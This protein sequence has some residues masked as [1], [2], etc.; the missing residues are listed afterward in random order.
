QDPPGSVLYTCEAFILMGEIISAVDSTSLDEVIRK[1]V[2]E[3]LGMKD[4]CYKPPV[5][6]IDRIAPTEYCSI[7]DRV[8]R[9]EVHDENAWVM[10]GVSGNA[11]IFS[12]A[13]DMTRIGAAMLD[14]LEKGTF[15]HKATAELMCRNYTPGMGENRGLGWMI[16]TR[17]TS[18]GDLLSPR[19]FGHTGF[20]GTSLWID[21][22]RKLY[23]LLLTNRVHPTRENTK[24]FRTR[25]IFH[26]LAVLTYGDC[27][28]AK[29][30]NNG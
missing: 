13:P 1:R 18:S 19:S 8:V 2:W 28:N 29:Q 30:G 16:A 27:N 17:G 5:S 21:P 25:N 7:R 4:T 26:N 10:G 14:S 24:L 15:L 11:G 6:L 3:P 23:A 12:C 22:D 9:G 20:T